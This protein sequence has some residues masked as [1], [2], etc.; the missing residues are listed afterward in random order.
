M[1]MQFNFETVKQ[2]EIPPTRGGGGTTKYDWSTFPAP[3][4]GEATKATIDVQNT[5]SLYTSIKKYREK[6][7]AGG[8]KEGDLPVFTLRGNK[9]KNTGKI[10]SVD[11]FRT[12]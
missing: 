8:T 12:K 9:D 4:D 1:T 3:K 7:L 6:L 10:V 5:K 2:E 11:V